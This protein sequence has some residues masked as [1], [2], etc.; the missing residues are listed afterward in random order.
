MTTT[1]SRYAVNLACLLCLAGCTATDLERHAGNTPALSLTQFFDGRLSAHG[2][3]KDWRGRVIRTFN[4]DILAYW[5]D[6]VGTL[7]E[8]FLFDDGEAQRRVWTLTPDGVDASGYPRYRGRAGDVVGTG[9][10]TQAGNAL[11]MDY[12]LR[13]A[14]GESTLDLRIDDRMYRVSDQ[15]VINESTMKKFGLTVGRIVLVIERRPAPV[16]S[17]AGRRPG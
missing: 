5:T 16:D 2:V 6:G 11:F 12:V 4:A 1:I 15:V 3:V 17:T 7:E 8:D 14:Y 10:A 9:R 13:I